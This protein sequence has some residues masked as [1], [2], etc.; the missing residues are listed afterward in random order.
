[1]LQQFG[2]A[3]SVEPHASD[4]LA[5]SLVLIE[6]MLW[7]RYAVRDG[8]V[9][10]SVHVNRPA[11]GDLVVIATD[12]VVRE[13]V[14]RRLTPERA[15]ELGLIRIYGDPAKIAWLRAMIAG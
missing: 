9:A 6:P 4:E 8:G 12:A 1:V 10:T 7:A 2:D 3:L 14:G 11:S 5:F 13:M 15:E